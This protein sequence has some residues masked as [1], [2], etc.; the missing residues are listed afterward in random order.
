[1]AMVGV[2]LNND[3]AKEG[4]NTRSLINDPEIPHDKEAKED[5]MKKELLQFCP[6]E[7]SHEKTETVCAS[8]GITY[9]NKCRMTCSAC[10]AGGKIEIVSQGK[11]KDSM[12]LLPST[13]TQEGDTGKG[14]SKHLQNSTRQWGWDR[15]TRTL[16]DNSKHANTQGGNTGMGDSKH[17]QNSTRQWGWDRITR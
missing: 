4:K 13:H 3:K 14:D 9:D 15:I 11:C 1:M 10:K 17:L 6:C 16:N 7:C 8:D 2:P 5:T 12:R